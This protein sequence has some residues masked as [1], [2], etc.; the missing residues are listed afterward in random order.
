MMIRTP[1]RSA[2]AEPLTK[3]LNWDVEMKPVAVEGNELSNYQSIVRNDNRNVLA[4]TKKSY[5][6][7][8]NQ[9]FVEVVSRIHEFTGFEVEGYTVFQQGRKVL[10]FLKNTERMKIADF[11]SDNYMVIG[12]SFDCSTGFFTGISHVLLRC[13]NQFSRMTVNRSIRHNKQIDVKLD[14]LVRFY[15]DYMDNQNRLKNT[16]E[17][18]SKISIS[19]GI[20]ETFVDHVLDVPKKVSA[21]KL[22]NKRSLWHSI[23]TEISSMGST[24]YGLFNGL[25]HYT[26]HTLKSSNKLFGNACGN[27]YKLNEKGFKY[28]EQLGV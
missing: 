4:I 2:I 12:N 1:R 22:N 24:A 26:T 20:A 18:W 5:H 7:A 25:T 13:T 14:E 21:M 6:P 23:N 10:A 19:R 15:K 17:S 9:R 27:A 28:L 8:T 16:F 3:T 11:D